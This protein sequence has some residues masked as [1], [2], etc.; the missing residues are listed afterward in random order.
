MLRSDHLKREMSTGARDDMGGGACTLRELVE[1]GNWRSKLLSIRFQANL[2][3]QDTGRS[4]Q[5]PARVLALAQPPKVWTN[6]VKQ[7]GPRPLARDFRLFRLFVE[8]ESLRTC[9]T[10][11]M[12][13][14]DK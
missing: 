7:R 13:G 12:E 2:S 9:W 5:M 3:H 6:S 14:R 1:T 4:R 11:E 8:S 10:S